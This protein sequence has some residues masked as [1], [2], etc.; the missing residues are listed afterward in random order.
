[1]LRCVRAGD[2][3]DGLL[4]ICAW[5]SPAQVNATDAITAFLGEAVHQADSTGKEIIDKMGV[6][7]VS[8]SVNMC[9]FESEGI[10]VH[11]QQFLKSV[12]SSGT[13]ERYTYIGLVSE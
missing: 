11:I 5:E 9:F 12:L 8:D 1:M 2:A 6:A 4:S 13:F 10:P 7:T 3:D